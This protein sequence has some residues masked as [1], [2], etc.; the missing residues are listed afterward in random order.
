MAG[1]H[2]KYRHLS[3]SSAHRQA[4]LR[5]LVTSLFKHET[6]ATTW[7]KAKEAQRLAEKLVTLGKKNTEATRR[8]ATQIFYEPNEMVPKLFGPIRERY[9]NRPG[10]YTR[11]LRIEPL[12]E[13]Q[14]ESA[15]L[16]LVDGPKDMRFA[17]TAKTLAR[18]PAK[19]GLSPGLTT[20]VKK[21]TQFREGGVE[22]LRE[23]VQRLRVEQKEGIDDRILPPPRKV[24]PE[25]KM[26][27]D[28]HY[29]EDV[30]YY[31]PA[32]PV[33]R[34]SARKEQAKQELIEDVVVEEQAAAPETKKEVS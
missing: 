1:G 28:M 21:V 5:N 15:I 6:I 32:N 25:D 27:R 18:R 20:H 14:A 10:G 12:K 34:R 11:V 26:K 29:F 4:L 2:M 9:A 22:S 3:R 24:Y 30:D 33:K 31:K 7:H 13:D 8:R 16:E 23:M 19:L 17:L